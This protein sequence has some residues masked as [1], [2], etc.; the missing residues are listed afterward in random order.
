MHCLDWIEG[1]EL[2]EVESDM[3]IW[4]HTRISTWMI[5]TLIPSSKQHTTLT[6]KR[7]SALSPH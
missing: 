5:C 6:A 4:S 3:R 7:P 1:G 2:V